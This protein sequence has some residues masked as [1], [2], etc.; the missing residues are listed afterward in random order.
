MDIPDELLT[1]EWSVAGFLLYGYW[2]YHAVR[3]APWR[4]LSGNSSLLGVFL[5]SSVA[6]LVIWSMRGGISPGI[7][8]H[9]LGV[10][11]LTLMFGWQLAWIG[12]SLTLIATTLNGAAGWSMF[13]L[14]A[15]LMG[16]LPILFAHQLHRVLEK[17]LPLNYFIY[18]LGNGFFGGAATILLTLAASGSIL[19][20]S[21]AYPT[22]RIDHELIPFLPLLMIPE[23]FLNGMAMAILV[24]F[25]PEWVTTFDD[26]R[27]INGK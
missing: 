27:Y 17:R 11:T 25:K 13:G 22:E 8:F 5:G 20:A 21:G 7:N 26:R 10:T 14:N 1:L 3:G 19:I 23:G 9:Y 16:G 6:L 4:R 24:G 2:L 18:V 12:V 15:L